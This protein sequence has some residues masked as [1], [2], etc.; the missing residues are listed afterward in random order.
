MTDAAAADWLQPGP[1]TVAPGVHRIPLPMPEDGLR[2]V[3]VYA[4]EDGHQ[5]TLI[6]GG[7]A[8]P[9]ARAELEKALDQLGY[10]LSGI[11]R[12]LVTHAHRD[13]YTLAVVLRREF[14]TAI[15]LGAGERAS[16]AAVTG[17]VNRFEA[18]I[19]L[20]RRAGAGILADGIEGG[21]SRID[22]LPEGWEEPDDWLAAG[23]LQVGQRSL[24]VLPTPGH[25][26]GHIVFADEAAGLLFAGDH[27]LPHITP[28]IGFEPVPADS[29]LADYLQSLAAVRALPDLTLLPAHGSVTASTHARIAELI[30]HHDQRLRETR[31][32]VASVA[33]ATAAQVA[34]AMAWTRRRR[35]FASL[36]PFNQMLAVTETVAHLRVLQQS[37][38][39]QAD[40]ADVIIYWTG[41]PEAP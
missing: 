34:A 35:T 33:S 11:G 29:P 1:E 7:W 15:G 27:V 13:H 31:A 6:D 18:Q 36:D 9:D 14:G 28:S 25:T 24:R 5:V 23:Q 37:G 32:A 41:S 4:L 3:N 17:R 2:A 26:R 40:G 8:V 38:T 21:D 16:I 39:V 20:L 30:A 12:I 22:P 10:P 19:N